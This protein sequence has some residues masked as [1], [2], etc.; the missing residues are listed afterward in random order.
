MYYCIINPSARS[1]IGKD[2]WTGLEYKFISAGLDYNPVFTKGPGHATKLMSQF[3][4]SA[5]DSELP[6][7]VIVLGG[8][9]T[10]NEAINGITDFEKVIVGFVPLGSSNDFSR[11]LNYPKEYDDLLERIID[12]QVIR[13]LDIGKLTYG[14]MTKPISRLCN[15]A[16][17]KVRYFGVSSGIGFDAAVCEEALA[18]GTKNFLNKIGL[19]KLTY[20]IIAI[21]QLLKADKIPCD[22]EFDNGR[23]VHLSHFLF[24]ASMIHHH[25][26]GG[27]RLAPKA[28]LT[29]GRFDLCIVGDMKRAKMFL[30]L[31][32]SFFGLHYIFKG[33]CKDRTS[34]IHIKT[35]I[36]MW[37]HT[38]GEVSVKSDDI[39]LEC[40]KQKLRLMT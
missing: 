18:S 8:D 31:P 7:K 14:S 12:G 3:I 25:E 33:V 39:T 37:V 40:L 5:K 38:D 15:D 36:P 10:L 16:P 2:I 32:F 20:G 13:T 34:K 26:G 17:E 19:G 21:K 22:I 4:E 30:A 28:N 1:G 9:G 27:F 24:I 23:K 11:D 35:M 6:I 29:D